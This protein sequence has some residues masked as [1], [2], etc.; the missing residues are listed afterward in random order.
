MEERPGQSTDSGKPARAWVRPVALIGGMAL[1]AGGLKLAGVEVTPDQVAETVEASGSWGMVVFASVVVA[2]NLMQ[3]PAW[4]FVLAAGSLWPFS[5]A[6]ALSYAST[7]LAATVTFEVFGRAGGTA[8]RDIEKPWMRK[9]LDTI[10]A[11]PV[12]GVALLR[13][14]LLITPPVTVAL[15]MSGVPRRAHLAGTA[16]GIIP[17]LVILLAGQEALW[18]GIQSVLNLGG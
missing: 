18:S 16:I 12:V 7:L 6:L 13:G 2:S 8:L 9:I 15:A 17:L 5:Q 4:I 1:L 11:R 10:D 3:I 14:F